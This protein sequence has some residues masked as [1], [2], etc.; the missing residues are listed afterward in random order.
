MS[1]QQRDVATIT[2][3]LNLIETPD[4]KARIEAAL[5]HEEVEESRVLTAD[6]SGRLLGVSG[7]SVFAFAKQGLLRRVKYPGRKI[8]G[9]F[10]E[11]DVRALLARSVEGAAP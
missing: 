1:A 11:S 7:R 6:E 5:R 10:L 2:A 9:G 8:G 4:L 3:L